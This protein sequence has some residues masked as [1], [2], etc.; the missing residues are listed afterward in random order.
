MHDTTTLI[1]K[2][3]FLEVK[4]QLLSI[5][6]YT[7]VLQGRQDITQIQHIHYLAITWTGKQW[8]GKITIQSF[9]IMCFICDIKTA[10]NKFFVYRFQ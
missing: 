5:T 6:I 7:Y 1:I 2:V 4:I 8:K 10:D 3:T 9:S